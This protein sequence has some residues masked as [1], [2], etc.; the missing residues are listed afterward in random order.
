[1]GVGGMLRKRKQRERR[2][3]RGERESRFPADAQTLGGQRA[4]GEDVGRRELLPETL[5]NVAGLRLHCGR[6]GA[7]SHH[8]GPLGR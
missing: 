5:R 3:A 8:P 6:E 1:M 2:R 7:P 4:D